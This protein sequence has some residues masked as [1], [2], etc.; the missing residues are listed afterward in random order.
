MVQ[1][2]PLH[3]LFMAD[4]IHICCL[5]NNQLVLD[6]IQSHLLSDEFEVHGFQ[7]KA[8]LFTYL[9][10]KDNLPDVLLLDLDLGGGI[11]QGMDLAKNLIERHPNLKIIICSVSGNMELIV[12]LI[13]I[14]IRGYIYNNPDDVDIATCLRNAIID[15]HY[16]KNFVFNYPIMKNLREFLE[17]SHFLN[18]P[19]EDLVERLRQ[20]PNSIEILRYLANGVKQADLYSK[21]YDKKYPPTDIYTRVNSIRTAFG[22]EHGTQLPYLISIA[23]KEGIINFDDIEFD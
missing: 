12:Q 17:Q 22:L 7:T 23:L 8:Q 13:K 15:V 18:K 20:I 10:K 11:I 9:E 6:G 4:K 5:D 1:K 3:F 21:L 2:L 19:N 16:G 14:G